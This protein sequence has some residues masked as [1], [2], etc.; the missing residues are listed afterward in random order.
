MSDEELDM[1]QPS[2]V[3]RQEW[4]EKVG[5]GCCPHCPSLWCWQAPNGWICQLPKVLAEDANSS[6]RAQ[7]AAENDLFAGR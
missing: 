4:G 2:E 6:K 5:L 7:T 3:Y 1:L